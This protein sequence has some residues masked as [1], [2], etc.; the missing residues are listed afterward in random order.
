MRTESRWPN[1][2]TVGGPERLDRDY[3]EEE[4]W[5]GADRRGIEPRLDDPPDIHMIQH[6]V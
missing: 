3:D 4:P 5:C 2:E 1:R 6:V